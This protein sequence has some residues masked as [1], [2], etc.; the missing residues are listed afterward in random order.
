VRDIQYLFRADE[1]KVREQVNASGKNVVLW[2]PFFGHK[3]SRTEGAYDVGALG[4]GGGCQE[5][6]DGVMKAI[7]SFKKVAAPNVGS[8]VLACHSGG[9]VAMRRMVEALGDLK[10]KLK[11][12]WGV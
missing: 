12:C 8:L 3:K 4:E 7:G 9:G 2:A 11:E 5:Y 1:S 10:G 6:L